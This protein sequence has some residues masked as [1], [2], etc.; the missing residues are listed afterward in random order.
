MSDCALSVSVPEFPW[1]K[2]GAEGRY[3]T[4]SLMTRNILNGGQL[5]RGVECQKSEGGE[6]GATT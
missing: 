6:G 1:L 5:V 2:E 4:R 3:L